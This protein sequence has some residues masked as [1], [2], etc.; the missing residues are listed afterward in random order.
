MEVFLAHSLRSPSRAGTGRDRDRHIRH[1]TPNSS[2]CCS[3]VE[4]VG[5]GTEVAAT[6]LMETTVLMEGTVPVEA[7]QEMSVERTQ[8]PPHS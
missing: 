6:V 2:H 3:R 8:I 4:G 7:V 5:T 1:L